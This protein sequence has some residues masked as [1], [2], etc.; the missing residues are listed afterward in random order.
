M[1]PVRV[2]GGNNMGLFDKVKDAVGGIYFA[3]RRNKLTD[4]VMN[5]LYVLYAQKTGEQSI[6][7]VTLDNESDEMFLAVFAKDYDIENIQHINS[8]AE[9]TYHKAEVDFNWIYETM[10]EC[11]FEYIG[12]HYDKYFD[13]ISVEDAKRVVEELNRYDN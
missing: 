13:V 6:R 10:I 3:R 7:L 2:E 4:A 8:N 12:I 1:H 11:G 5:P 9:D